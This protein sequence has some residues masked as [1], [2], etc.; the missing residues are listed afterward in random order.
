VVKVNEDLGK[1]NG[2][3]ENLSYGRS[4][5]CVIEGEALDEELPGLKIGKSAVA[6]FQQD[7]DRF[8]AFL[9]QGND[10]VVADPASL[11]IGAIEKLDNARWDSA[12]REFFGR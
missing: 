2:A 7:I 1:G 4:W 6:L 11:C 9:Q 10:A 12:V 5:V 3:L 8:R